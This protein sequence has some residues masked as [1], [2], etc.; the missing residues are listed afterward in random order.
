[1][2]KGLD[3]KDIRQEMLPVYGGKCLLGKAVHKWVKKRGKYF[4][5]DEEIETEMRKCL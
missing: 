1:V 4:A 3:A 2:D 5:D